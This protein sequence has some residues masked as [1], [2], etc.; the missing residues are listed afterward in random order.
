MKIIILHG[1]NI[2]DSYKR[3][4]LFKNEAKRRNW[5]IRYIDTKI[6]IAEQLSSRHLFESSALFVLEEIGRV[7]K[8]DLNWINKNSERMDGTLIIYSESLLNKGLLN[9]ISNVSKVEEYKLPVLIW[10]LLESIYPKNSRNCIKLLHEVLKKENPEFVFA[11]ISKQVR[12]MYW[13]NLENNNLLYQTWR[14]SKLRSQAKK[15]SSG[16]LKEILGRLSV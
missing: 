7:G 12:D 5:E 16:E 9:S 8:K 15:F 3:L 10:K 1:D 4:R 11:L 14:I 13:S 6:N 2:S